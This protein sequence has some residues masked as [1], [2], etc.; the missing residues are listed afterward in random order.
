MTRVRRHCV[1]TLAPLQDF[2]VGELATLKA[3]EKT[4]VL[5]HGTDLAAAERA[6]RVS[7]LDRS[8][9]FDRIGVV[10][11]RGTKTEIAAARAVP[12][13]T[14]LEGNQPIELTQEHLQHRDARR[15]GLSHPHR[16][17]RQRA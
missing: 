8:M 9:S 13:V 3:G 15:R 12:G 11:A 6:V 2:L 10:V 1:S 7:G 14:Y 4:T 16:R 5:V 17:G